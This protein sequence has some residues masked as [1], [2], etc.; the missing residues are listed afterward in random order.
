MRLVIEGRPRDAVAKRSFD[1]YVHR[2]W[3]T[4]NLQLLDNLSVLENVE[5]FSSKK[6]NATDYLKKLAIPERRWRAHISKLSG[7]ELQRVAIAQCLASNA[8]LVVLDEPLKGLDKPLRLVLFDIFREASVNKNGDFT[9]ICVDH[10]FE[11]IAKHFDFVYE[12]IAGYQ[13][14]I[15]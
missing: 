8:S 7:G 11:Y 10:D 9:M 5:V 2:F 15:K 6:N 4:Q 14:P 1:N 12:V 3:L 13:F